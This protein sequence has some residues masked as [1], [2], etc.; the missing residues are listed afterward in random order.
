MLDKMGTKVLQ[1]KLN[2]ELTNHIKNMLPSIINN[3]EDAQEGI[4]EQLKNLGYDFNNRTS[5]NIQ[6]RLFR[7]ISNLCQVIF[8]KVF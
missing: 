1:E 6:K 7:Y 2:A 8:S 4:D 5:S 3:L